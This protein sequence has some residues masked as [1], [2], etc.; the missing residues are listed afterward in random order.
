M[1]TFKGLLPAV[2]TPF[3]AEFRFYLPAFERLPKRLVSN[4]RQ[5]VENAP[6][7]RVYKHVSRTSTTTIRTGGR[8]FS[9]TLVNDNNMIH[10]ARSS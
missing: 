3:D 5:K 1:T 9:L 2:V 7:R 6:L 4:A 10:D 8:E